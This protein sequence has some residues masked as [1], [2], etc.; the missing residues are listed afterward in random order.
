[1]KKFLSLVL[2]L[3]MTASLVTISAGAKDFT[4]DSKIT[5]KEAVDVI[6][7]IG[8]VDGYTDGN[9]QP[10]TALTRGAAAKIICNLVLGPTTAEALTADAAPFKDVPTDHVFAGYIA[11]CAQ[12]GIINGYSDGT[13]RPAGT[14]NGYAFM[15]MLL[16]ALGYD[17]S[18]ENFTG[19]NW[20]IN[21]AKLAKNLKLDDGNSKFVGSAAVTREEACLYAFNT[22]QATMVEYDNASTIVVG[23][24]TVKG[25]AT[26]KNV[27][28]TGYKDIYESDKVAANQ[29]LQFGEKYFPKLTLKTGPDALGRKSNTWTYKNAEVGTYATEDALLTY[30]SDMSSTSGKSDVKKA[31]KGYDLDNATVYYNGYVETETV[32][33]SNGNKEVEKTGVTTN[34]I[35]ELTGNGIL[36]EVYA[37][38]TD[39]TDV[40]VIDSYVGEVT[41]VNKTD[42]TITVEFKDNQGASRS[43]IVTSEGYGVF[44]KDDIV[45]VS[46]VYSGMDTISTGS[47]DQDDAVVVAAEKVTGKV[48]AATGTKVTLD[49][50]AYKVAEINAYAQPNAKDDVDVYLDAYGYAVWTSNVAAKD[51]VYAVWTYTDT[52]KYGDTDTYFQGVKTDGTVVEYKID[53]TGVTNPTI[54]NLY[55]YKISGS[56]IKLTN[57]TPASS[58]VESY[59]T[60]FGKD[61]GENGK[62]ES[63]T[64][65]LGNRYFTDDTVFISVKD[66]KSDLKVTVSTGKQLV[67]DTDAEYAIVAAA[68]KKSTASA[69]IAVVFVNTSAVTNVKDL[70]LLSDNAANGYKTL[71]DTDYDTYE[72]YINGEKQD[73]AVDADDSDTGTNDWQNGNLFTYGLNED[74]AYVLARIDSGED[75]KENAQVTNV[76]KNLLTVAGK[77]EAIDASDA[78]VVDLTDNDI[79]DMSALKDLSEVDGTKVIV[80]VVFD[81]DDNALYVYIVDATVDFTQAT[82]GGVYTLTNSFD[83]DDLSSISYKI[84]SRTYVLN[85]G[86]TEVPANAKSVKVSTVDGF[87]F[88]GNLIDA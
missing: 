19:P 68:E 82:A 2:A 44:E 87:T 3:V 73:I 5:Y 7:T 40:V 39:V 75:V 30:T 74:G 62:I 69:D 56:K 1:M 26:R 34:E 85:D 8:V 67:K 12:Q 47:G 86:E 17:G 78:K 61:A 81:S 71:N 45:M 37:D 58:S 59:V 35:A 14:L 9:F 50:T 27:E 64:K 21:V 83:T 4:D 36:V 48:T 20:T 11:Y 57:V 84:G 49:G 53:T 77:T 63:S 65:K 10:T 76:Y 25:N 29:T 6:S 32:S 41:K 46:P 43:S 42:E 18:I 54:G 51:F 79:S 16:G 52:D 72:V 60:Y 24:V 13:F 28:Q 31:L 70:V 80:T 15:K 88:D 55:S 66:N 38:G 33:T 23:N 22:L